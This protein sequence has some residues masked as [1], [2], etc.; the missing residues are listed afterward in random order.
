[1]KTTRREKQKGTANIWL[2][3]TLGVVV[4]FA[5]LATDTTN[6]AWACEHLQ[7]AA[8]TAARWLWLGR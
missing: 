3:F 4:A 1:M 5:V 7:A 2:A 8:D 6:M